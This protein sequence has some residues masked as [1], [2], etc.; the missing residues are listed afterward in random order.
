MWIG[1]TLLLGGAVAFRLGRGDPAT[2]VVSAPVGD[3]AAGTLLEFGSTRCA[4]CKAMHAELGL[5]R[6][7]C[8]DGPRITE[9]D[10]FADEATP[11]RY[12]VQV[13]PTQVL[14]NA[15][16]EEFDRHEGFLPRGDIVARFEGNGLGCRR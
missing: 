9:I 11:A 3:S 12:G 1:T 15:R 8:A 5:L 14:L 6:E 4:G 10:V 16:G 2:A 7:E 13:I